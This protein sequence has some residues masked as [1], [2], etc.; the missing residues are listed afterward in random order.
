MRAEH[1]DAR[2]VGLVPAGCRPPLR[3]DLAEP[4]LAGNELLGA[5]PVRDV[6]S[7]A[8]AR[9]IAVQDRLA[10]RV[11]IGRGIDLV[12]FGLHGMERVEEA[13]EHP[14]IGGAADGAGIGREAVENDGGL[15]AGGRAAAEL[16]ATRHPL[17]QRLDA[18]GAGHHPPP[19]G[20]ALA[21]AVAAVAP[22]AADP[23]AEDHRAGRA[24]EFGDRHHDRGLD[25]GEAGLA[26]GPLVE[27]LEFQRM[28]RDVGHVE[29]GE[30]FLGRA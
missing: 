3:L 4:G 13:L 6:R 1:E 27:P 24:V 17:G 2:A 12:A 21:V 14:E 23:A 22:L 19:G 28:G 10:Q 26:G 18:V 5:D 15:A 11:D 8:V 7:L 20:V 30:G 16:R 25:R 9:G 29:V